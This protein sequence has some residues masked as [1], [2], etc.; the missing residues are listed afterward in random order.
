MFFVT[1]IIFQGGGTTGRGG[2]LLVRSPIWPAAALVKMYPQAAF[3]EI[4]LY[5]STAHILSAVVLAP[6]YQYTVQTFT[7]V[8]RYFEV[9]G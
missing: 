7:S 6:P 5:L 2:G 1:F 3:E 8:R 9:C 4:S